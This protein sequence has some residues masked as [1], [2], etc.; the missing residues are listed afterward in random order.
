MTGEREGAGRGR[1]EGGESRDRGERGAVLV[2]FALILPFLLML[3]FGIIEFS[4]AFSASAT[5]SNASRAGARIASA[6]PRQTGFAADVATAVATA[7]SP[8]PASAPQE[9]WVYRATPGTGLPD[10]GGFS[11]RC[12]TCVVYLW[13]ASAGNFESSPVWDGWQ[14]EDQDACGGTADDIGVYVKAEHAFDT[15]LFLTSKT[16]SSKTVMRLEPVPSSQ[17]C[18][19]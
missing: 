17:A 8:L 3:T 10:S 2:E 5:V 14:A 13:D 16:L 19:P 15:N 1:S 11:T 12:T 6:E 4:R 18:R 7:L 9:V